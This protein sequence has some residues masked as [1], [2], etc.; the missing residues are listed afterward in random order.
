[1]ILC[2]LKISTT[3]KIH[4]CQ[5][6]WLNLKKIMAPSTNN[7]KNKHPWLPMTLINRFERSCG[8]FR[9]GGG[10]NPLLSTTLS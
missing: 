7:G 2:N 5:Q 1:M 9:G 6:L 8:T 3:F 10:K 4:C